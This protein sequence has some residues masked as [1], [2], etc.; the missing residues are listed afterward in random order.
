MQ[1]AL[2]EI[3]GIY[4]AGIF[5]ADVALQPAKPPEEVTRAFDDAIKAREDEQRYINEA[6]A[7]AMK[8]EPVADGKAARIIRAAEAFRQQVV[9]QATAQTAEFLAVL[10]EYVRSPQV[11]RNRLYLDAMEQVLTHTSKLYLDVKGGSNMLYLPLDKIMAQQKSFQSKLSSVTEQPI[12]N[13]GNQTIVH[14]K[15][16]PLKTGYIREGYGHEAG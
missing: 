15:L 3:M 5:I 6:K 16:P 8:V 12:D 10:P 13:Q 2:T 7:Y 9:L 14:E 1:Q 4:K 11:T